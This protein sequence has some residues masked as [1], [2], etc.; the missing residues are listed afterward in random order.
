M[1]DFEYE[2][3]NIVFDEYQEEGYGIK[4]KNYEICSDVLPLWWYDCK[5]KY[6]CTNCDMMF[7]T[8]S[9][10]KYEQKGRGILIFKDNTVCPLC[11]RFRRTVSQPSC[12]HFACID[13]FKKCWYTMP[14]FPYPEIEDDYNDQDNTEWYIKY[15][16]L[17]F[18]D[19]KYKEW[20]NEE[21][22]YEKCPLCS[23]G[24]ERKFYTCYELIKQMKQAS[25]Y[26][27]L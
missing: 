6:I 10:A 19:K 9:S 4:C 8:W 11:F 12:N 2:K 21:L 26:K 13:C 7:G 14:S 15:P 27:R 20:E 23:H 24:G 1:R 17:L 18:Y 25:K 16:L 22:G 5:G 3:N